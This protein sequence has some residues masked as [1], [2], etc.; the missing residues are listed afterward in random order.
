MNAVPPPLRDS[1]IELDE[2]T[3]GRK[4][5]FYLAKSWARWFQ[6][7]L[8]A[9]T[10]TTVAITKTTPL[11]SQTAAIT[12]SSA[13]LT[14]GPGLFRVSWLIRVSVAASVSSALQV[15]IGWVRSGIA[16]TKVG[17]SLTGNTTTT[18]ESGSTLV[19]ADGLTDI[20]Y[21]VTYA[22][23]GTPCQFEFDVV[24]EQLA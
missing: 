23:S 24:V 4:E 3:P 8:L 9:R 15:T 18:Y 20:T 6:E 14:L 2:S 13:F 1:V 22:S 19:R 7:S 21:A 5:P 17:A 16:Q 12:T 10:N 11:V